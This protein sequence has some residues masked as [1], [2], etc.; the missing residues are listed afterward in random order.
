M[1]ISCIGIVAVGVIMLRP[2]DMPLVHSR[3][4]YIVMITDVSLWVI[5]VIYYIAVFVSK[6]ESFVFFTRGWHEMSNW[7]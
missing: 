5:N 7:Y 4:L 6:Y 1:D 2:C 3:N